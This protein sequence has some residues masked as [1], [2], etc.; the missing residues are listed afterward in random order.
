[1]SVPNIPELP[2]TPPR[3]HSIE[4]HIQEIYPPV[5]GHGEFAEY[6]DAQVNMF[7]AQHP[8]IASVVSPIDPQPQILS[9][10]VASSDMK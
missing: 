8:Q 6:T 5:P 7:Q 2:P 4:R 3:E 1:M 9:T 10:W